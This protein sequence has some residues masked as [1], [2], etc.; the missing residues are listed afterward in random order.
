MWEIMYTIAVTAVSTAISMGLSTCFGKIAQSVVQASAASGE[1]LNY[2]MMLSSMM[3]SSSVSGLQIVGAM[4]SETGQELMLDPWID[5]IV[6]GLAADAGFSIEAQMVFCTIAETMREAVSGPIAQLIGHQS[7]ST[8]LVSELRTLKQ[9]GKDITGVDI[10]NAYSEIQ[11]QMQAEMAQESTIQRL[12]GLILSTLAAMA[13]IY[14]GLGVFASP[15]MSS[16]IS[17]SVNIFIEDRNQGKTIKEFFK[18]SIIK[19]AQVGNSL[20]ISQVDYIG[21]AAKI[22]S[23]LAA[24]IGPLASLQSIGLS[25]MVHLYDKDDLRIKEFSFKGK[26]Y[27]DDYL[28]NRYTSRYSPVSITGELNFNGLDEE[29]VDKIF[30]LNFI[31]GF[32]PWEYLIWL[33]HYSQTDIV[34]K[35]GLIKRHIRKLD[36]IPFR[37]PLERDVLI[38]KRIKLLY[39]I[40]RVGPMKV[41]QMHIIYAVVQVKDFRGND[42]IRSL[43]NIGVTEQK[44]DDPINKRFMQ[45]IYVANKGLN[46]IITEKQAHIHIAIRRFL[47]LEKM[48]FKIPKS[49]PISDYFTIIPLDIAASHEQMRALETF[50]TMYINRANNIFGYDLRINLKYNRIAGDWGSQTKKDVAIIDKEHIESLVELG[51]RQDDVAV[52]FGMSSRTFYDNYWKPIFGESYYSVQ[53]ELFKAR[54]KYLA[55]LGVTFDQLKNH[56]IQGVE[57]TRVVKPGEELEFRHYT[58]NQILAMCGRLL[59]GKHQYDRLYSRRF[60]RTHILDIF[61]SGELSLQG[62]VESV[63]EHSNYENIIY[64]TRN[65]AETEDFNWVWDSIL[66]PI[67]IEKIKAG[68]TRS[69][70]YE[71][72]NEINL[73]R[74]GDQSRFKEKMVLVLKRTFTRI[75]KLEGKTESLLELYR[76]FRSSQI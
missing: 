66:K 61:S 22:R 12:S 43:V 42:L 26:L 30:V 5:G 71:I 32:T 9:T 31:E 11:T 18:D 51:L 67:F 14:S 34:D 19:K 33:E 57:E 41:D 20:K 46:Y 1:A 27:S 13:L 76:L 68:P 6:G 65:V 45:K 36:R 75:F 69:T 54:L 62:L 2:P 40:M 74:Q 60:V 7:S 17:T 4:A 47:K 72:G 55:K 63:R 44:G 50:W 53:N 38:S 21:E 28:I 73:I 70:W 58:D 59:G 37:D 52:Y 48:G 25:K 8:D 23:E 49:T 3:R 64:G 29:T 10:M 16:M 56:F 24:K 39:N 35:L 15:L